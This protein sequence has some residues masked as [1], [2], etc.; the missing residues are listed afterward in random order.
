MTS[1]CFG[2]LHVHL[3]ECSCM[4]EH[5]WPVWRKQIWYKCD[6]ASYIKLAA[7]SWYIF[8]TY[9][10]D[11]RSHLYQKIYRLERADNI[12]AEYILVLFSL[13]NIRW[14]SPPWRF[15]LSSWPTCHLVLLGRTKERLMPE[16]TQHTV[17]SN[18]AST[19]VMLAKHPVLNPET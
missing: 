16:C 9:I 15:R 17:L 7:S 13:C 4:R 11:A 2:H 5:L 3:Q 18:H 14:L 19:D 12:H 6:R 8:F 10:H 1:T